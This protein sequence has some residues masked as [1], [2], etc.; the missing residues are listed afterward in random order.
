MKFKPALIALAASLSLGAA[1]AV[2]TV[3]LG[4][5]TLEYDETTALGGLAFTSSGG[6]LLGFGWNL[7]SSFQAVSLSGDPAGAS[8]ALPWFK[9]TVNPG[10]VL[11]GQVEGFIG[12]L[13]YNLVGAG[14]TVNA[15]VEGNLQIDGGNLPLAMP[16]LSTVVASAPGF[17][18]GY[19]SATQAANLG[20]GFSTLE[21]SGGVLVLSAM[22]G[23]FASIIAQPQN[24]LAMSIAAAEVPEP[25]SLA[26]MLGG[27]AAVGS[28]VQ[29]RRRAG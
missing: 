26:L 15:S 29:R 21:F 10:Y 20:G 17:E 19:L 7:P 3:N 12:N 2:E 13:V 5:F 9:L 6:G 8:F 11:S 18:S 24:M 4:A 28:L 23:S 14:A 27:L 22:G 25:A 16:L 1:Q